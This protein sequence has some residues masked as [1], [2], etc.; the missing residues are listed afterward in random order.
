MR[1]LHMQTG[2][3]TSR[4]E[5]APDSGSIDLSYG[6]QAGY[7]NLLDSHCGDY[8]KKNGIAWMWRSWDDDV[9]GWGVLDA[10]GN[11]KFDIKA[12]TTC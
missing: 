6:S 9:V 4:E 1:V 12:K 3:S 11:P 5:F 7:W 8:F 10:N 2:W